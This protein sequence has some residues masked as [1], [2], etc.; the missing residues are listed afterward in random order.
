MLD[1]G[2]LAAGGAEPEVDDRR[3][4]G[5]RLVAEDHHDL[6]VA[7]RRK[8]QPERVE[9]GTRLLGEHG[10]VRGEPFAQQPAERVG[11]LDG[12]GAGER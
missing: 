5:D 1:L 7:N 11:L 4:L 12:L 3:A 9:R 6:S 8:R 2:A 10:R